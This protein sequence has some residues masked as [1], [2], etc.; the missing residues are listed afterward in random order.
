MCANLELVLLTISP[1][2]ENKVLIRLNSIIKYIIALSLIGFVAL[3]AFFSIRS[4][5]HKGN[6][7]AAILNISS[8]QAMYSQRIALY[9]NL[10]NQ[11][12]QLRQQE[13]YETIIKELSD[14][15][16]IAHYTLI[17]GSEKLPVIRTDAIDAVYYEAPH[18]LNKKIQIFLEKIEVF[19]NSE[20]SLSRQ[21]AAIMINK[22][23][24]ESLLLSLEKMHDEYQVESTRISTRLEN[25]VILA[26]L[27]I[28]GLIILEGVFIFYPLALLIQKHEKDLIRQNKRLVS[29]N[30]DLE[31]FIYAASHDLKTPIR[32]LNTLIQFMEDDFSDEL[33]EKAKEYMDLIKKR[34]GLSYA[35]IDGLMRY[36]AISRERN[37]QTYYDLNAFIK[38]L[39]DETQEKYD[40]TI[41]TKGVLPVL[42]TNPIWINEIFANL[43]ENAI[44]HNNKR[45]FEIVI[46]YEDTPELH[47][48]H[49]KDN[50]MG[51][52]KKYHD[53]IFKL[54]Q[55]IENKE[56]N[57]TAGIG[58][59]I[60]KKIIMEL[61]G[62]VWIDSEKN[63]HF[64]IYFTIPKE[65][66]N[67]DL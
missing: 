38:R 8:K 34:V 14:S 48:F 1:K 39:I 4:L 11:S 36:G 61:G 5:I 63:E 65:D 18:N 60:V 3:A 52:E 21:Y 6:K 16:K 7:N 46:T 26:V 66:M 40:V 24:V 55:T 54:F 33:S 58:L 42:K 37:I 10:S 35:L 59:A 9:T 13:A 25:Q 47:H 31:Q 32:G 27:L 57:P 20:D 67:I 30:H 64:T 62:A 56:E 23:A 44:K 15:I 43:I 28:L 51:V 12:N 45:N 19:I 22:M 17:N 49:I 41:L 53:K 50:G 2:F 29:L